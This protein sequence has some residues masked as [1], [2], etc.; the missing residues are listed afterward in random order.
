MEKLHPRGIVGLGAAIG[1]AL[2]AAL[3]AQTTITSP[4]MF[5]QPGQYYRA[6]AN[7]TNNSSVSVNGMIG[8]AG[9]GQFW[10]FTTGPSDVIYRF[11]Y[12]A[13]SNT[14]Y[15]AAFVAAP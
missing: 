5:N 7:S 3:A 9:A 1:L 11:D 15:G 2:P 6:Y 10:D 12:L 14:P 8:S 4:D 13:A